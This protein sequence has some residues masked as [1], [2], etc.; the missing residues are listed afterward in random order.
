MQDEGTTHETKGAPGTT[1]E[2]AVPFGDFAPTRFG[3][4]VR[5]EG[6]RQGHDYVAEVR[7]RF[8][9]TEVDV[10]IDGVRHTPK[11][12]K[13][14]ATKDSAEDVTTED[15]L[16][17][18]FDE[19][20]F[21]H[22]ITVR[23]PTEKGRMKDGEQLVVRTALPG[24]AGE[25]DVVGAEELR[26]TP[27]VP[28][29][30]STSAAREARKAEHPVRF[31]LIAAGAQAMRYLLP[32]LGIGALLSG[33]L[34]PVKRW[35]AERAAPVTSWVDEATRGIRE[36]VGGLIRPVLDLI[37][38]VLDPVRS[39]LNRLWDLL[40][41]WIPEIHLG[42]DLPGWVFDWLVP[43]LVVVV[44]FLVTIAGIRDRRDRLEKARRPEG[45]QSGSG[46]A[47]SSPEEDEED[48]HDG[49]AEQDA[50]EERAGK[51]E[52]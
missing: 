24:A 30:G 46:A 47:D 6:S 32:L 26:G 33:L 14:L 5:Y 41:G 31:G 43:V 13:A 3:A 51:Q 21:R 8:L 44:V 39:A 23:R 10:V 52:Q 19:G 25:V 9:D 45:M 4:D 37:D 38:V 20:L 22:R 7:H 49:E 16:A 35:I 40:F 29:Q 2:D 12:E 15:G 36:W 11:P 48:V 17:I 18:R 27:L 34:D 28:E 1:S 42:L 50:Q